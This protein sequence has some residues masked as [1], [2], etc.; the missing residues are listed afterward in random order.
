[1][2]GYFSFRRS[3]GARAITFQQRRAFG[4]VSN[5]L[6]GC[7]LSGSFSAPPGT[8][9]SKG[10]CALLSVL[11]G[12]FVGGCGGGGSD[13]AASTAEV[14]S[15]PADG[16]YAGTYV[17]TSSGGDATITAVLPTAT[18][19]LSS[20]SGSVDSQSVAISCTG[21]ITANGTFAVSAIDANGITSTYTGTASASGASGNY[22]VSN[23]ALGVFTC[24]H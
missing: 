7:G 17:C 13:S 22:S 19:A 4:F 1:M 5:V 11:I 15:A 10:H 14:S 20:C 18:G 16:S 9:L 12:A 2:N 23:G 21:S 6:A 3:V 8:R 24:T